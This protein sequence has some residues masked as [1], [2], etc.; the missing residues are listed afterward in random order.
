VFD[1]LVSEQLVSDKASALGIAAGLGHAEVVAALLAAGAAPNAGPPDALPLFLAGNNRSSDASLQRRDV[2]VAIQLQLLAAG[3]SVAKCLP[4]LAWFSVDIAKLSV[5]RAMVQR[6]AEE[7][8]AGQYA[9][10]PEDRECCAE[11]LQ[12][13]ASADE[14]AAFLRFTSQLLPLLPPLGADQQQHP[15]W[16]VATSAAEQAAGH[17]A[18]AVLGWLF[19]PEAPPESVWVAAPRAEAPHL[20]TVAAASNQPAAVTLLLDSGKC[21]VTYE[22]A[23][24]AAQRHAHAGLAA[25]L[26]RAVP[27]VPADFIQGK[28]DAL[29]G[30]P[31]LFAQVTLRH[32][33]QV[34]YET[35]QTPP[36][37]DQRS[38]TCACKWAPSS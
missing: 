38:E 30:F 28:A 15:W 27:L 19:G 24:S 26:Q 5:K 1:A 13:A 31:C 4:E 32:V 10:S 6:L 17:G 35:A 37:R 34:I 20:L 22:P 9:F 36:D 33:M 7:H 21:A 14:L 11:V 25:L 3:A 29:A 12:A 23:Q 18:M 16:D 2:A 8:A